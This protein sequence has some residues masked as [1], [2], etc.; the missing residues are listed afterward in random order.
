MEKEIRQLSNEIRVLEDSRKI[1]GYAA[2]FDSASRDMGFT[3]YIDRGAFDGVLERSDVFA[4]LNH[5]PDKV[6]ARWNRGNGSLKL[7]VDERGLKYEFD[8]PHTDLGNSLL[9]F[10]KRGELTESSFAFV[11]EKDSWEKMEDGTYVRHIVH[12]RSLH[13]VSPCWTAAYA[14]TSVSCRSF[15][16]FKAEEAR[17]AAEEAERLAQEQRDAEEKAKEEIAEQL[18]AYYSNLRAEN[19]KYLKK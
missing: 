4:V 5:Q 2:V 7:S 9:E 13:D 15:E 1:E 8:A 3:E 10:V 18:A 19:D 14:D 17:K 11:V 16:E 6:L 12:L